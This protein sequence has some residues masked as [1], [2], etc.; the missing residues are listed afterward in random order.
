M[1]CTGSYNRRNMKELK[2]IETIYNGYR[3]RSRLEARWA[4]FFDTLG[5]EYEYEPEGFELGDGVRYLPDFRIK[6]YGTRGDCG[7]NP[8]DLYV[9]VKGEMTDYDAA[10]IKKFGVHWITDLTDSE[11][12]EHLE[13]M[14]LL[15]VGDIPKVNDKS[16]VGDSYVFHSYEGMDSTDILPFNYD[17]IDGDVFAAYPAVQKGKFFLYGDD[18]NYQHGAD[19]A[20]L[21]KA[22][23]AA[24]SARFEH[25][26]TPRVGLA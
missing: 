23:K 15:V 10:K 19:E 2:P 14:P 18:S 4:V 25:G 13:G 5:I 17:T 26:E 1:S 20:K 24:R 8:F 6:C 3:F 16:E 7:N 11:N 12:N 21:V 9:E 22:Y